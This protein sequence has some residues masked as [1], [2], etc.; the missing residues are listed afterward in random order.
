MQKLLFKTKNSGALDVIKKP[1]T[2]SELLKSEKKY[3]KA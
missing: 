3:F 2:P 1:F